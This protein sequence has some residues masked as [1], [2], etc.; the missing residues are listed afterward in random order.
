M[1]TFVPIVVVVGVAVGVVVGVSAA[2]CDFGNDGIVEPQ[3]NAFR[4]KVEWIESSSRRD[5]TIDTG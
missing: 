2:N 3:E 5:L 4:S 1:T